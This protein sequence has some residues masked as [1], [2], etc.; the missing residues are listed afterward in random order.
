[1][2]QLHQ[3]GRCKFRGEKNINFEGEVRVCHVP[4]LEKKIPDVN[5]VPFPGGG[6]IEPYTPNSSE[7]LFS[8]TLLFVTRGLLYFHNSFFVALSDCHTMVMMS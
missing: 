7:C 4:P 5:S 2:C 8:F 6:K 1:M 3:K